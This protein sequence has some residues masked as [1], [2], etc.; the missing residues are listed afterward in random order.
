L[1]FKISYALTALCILGFAGYAQ[2]DTTGTGTPDQKIEIVTKSGSV[3]GIQT[4]NQD[5]PEELKLHSPR[6]A[7]IMSAILPGLGQAYNK[8]YWK[9]PIIYG[10]FAISGYYLRD[11]LQNINRYKEAY[12]AEIDGDPN[13]VNNTGFNTTQ[14]NTLIDQYTQWRDLSYIALGIIY[15]LNIVDAS[16][17]AHLMYFDVSDDISMRITPSWSPLTFGA[18]G[19]TLTVKL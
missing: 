12:I 8:K 13:T 10:G 17:D 2:T 9:I 18:P 4:E 7:T 1:I 6:K 14:L 15:I 11:N 3:K 19:L 5:L 16:V